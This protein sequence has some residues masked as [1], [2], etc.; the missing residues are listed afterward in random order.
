MA[1]LQS[2]INLIRTKTGTSPQLDAIETSLRR[3]GY[4]GVVGFLCVSLVCAVIYILFN[5]SKQNLQSS[6]R[7]LINE[8]TGDAKKEGLFVSIK[9]RTFIVGN[10]MQNQRPWADLLDRINIFVPAGSLTDI[11]VDDQDK[12]SLSMNVS[13]FEALLQVVNAIITQTQSNHLVNPQLTS[14]QIQA[15]GGILA[16]VTF[17][18]VF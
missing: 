1:P 8:V 2:S 11:V 16:S 7:N 3:T 17:F 9:N 4:V 12:I 15:N 10:A 6:K 5:Q 14:I 18:A 13:S